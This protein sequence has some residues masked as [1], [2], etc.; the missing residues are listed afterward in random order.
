M[1]V[2][3]N[4]NTIYLST[5]KYSFLCRFCLDQSPTRSRQHKH[6]LMGSISIGLRAV[7]VLHC[8]SV[9]TLRTR[10]A[11]LMWVL[12]SLKV[13]A[14]NLSMGDTPLQ[15]SFQFVANHSRDPMIARNMWYIHENFLIWI[16]L[17]TY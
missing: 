11:T 1:V 13:N 12:L 7:K 14:S 2:L 10:I 3:R 16:I 6:W 17:S 5:L 9:P 8:G 15:A 4:P